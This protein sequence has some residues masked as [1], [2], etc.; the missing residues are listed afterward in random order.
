MVPCVLDRQNGQSGEGCEV[1]SIL[2]RYERS[3]GD[4]FVR[5]WARFRRAGL[6][7]LISDGWICGVWNFI[8]RKVAR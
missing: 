4:L 3:S 6:G 7:R 1:E 8:V 5:S 2:F